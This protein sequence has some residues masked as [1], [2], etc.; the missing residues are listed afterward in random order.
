[1]EAVLA[2]SVQ[3]APGSW[4]IVLMVAEPP[5]GVLD[6]MLEALEGL[7]LPPS[8]KAE[9]GAGLVLGGGVA[10]ARRPNTAL[11]IVIAVGLGVLTVFLLI[12]NPFSTT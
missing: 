9:G 11:N 12:K 6:A 8:A 2:A 1:M 4:A 3:I 5:A 7:T 10:D